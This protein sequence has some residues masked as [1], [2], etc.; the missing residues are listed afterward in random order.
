MW[1]TQSNTALKSM[2]DG[3]FPR[4]GINKMV[5]DPGVSLGLHFSAYH[6]LPIWATNLD[7]RT[8][9]YLCEIQR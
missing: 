4:V 6:L 5:L 2:N 7:D 1:P 3:E 9:Y 8:Y